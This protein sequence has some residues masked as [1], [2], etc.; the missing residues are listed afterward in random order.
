MKKETYQK[1]SIHV[2]DVVTQKF[3][4]LSNA[5]PGDGSSGITE[6]NPKGELDSKENFGGNLWADDDQDWD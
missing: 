1:P 3:I 4:A 6:G 5:N 2:L